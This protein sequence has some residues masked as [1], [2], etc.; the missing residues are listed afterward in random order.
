MDARLKYSQTIKDIISRHAGYKPV[1]GEIDSRPTFDD[2]RGTYALLQVGWEGDEYVHGAVI[3][4]DL[5]D[6]KVWI[7]YDG[8][9]D[10]VAGELVE[11]GI[12]R[13]MIVLG[14]RPPEIRK[15]TE[16]GLGA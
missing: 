3:H 12:P 6:G 8:T 14:F 9:E 4:I 5:I 10:G 11:A 13:D 2:A 16:F 15:Y 7:Q 1:Y